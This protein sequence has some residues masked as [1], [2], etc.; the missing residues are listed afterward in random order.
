M[1]RLLCRDWF[2]NILKTNYKYSSILKIPRTET[3]CG[4]SYQWCL[5]SNCSGDMH[6]ILNKFR[7]TAVKTAVI[8][9]EG[10]KEFSKEIFS[11]SNKLFCGSAF[12]K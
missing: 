7:I 10:I 4:A 1:R 5:L 3:D 8:R 12:N 6:E 11:D 2:Y 9:L